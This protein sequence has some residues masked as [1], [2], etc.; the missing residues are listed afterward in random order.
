MNIHP[1]NSIKNI[2]SGHTTRFADILIK[3]N[4]IEEVV[5]ADDNGLFEY[6]IPSSINDNTKIELTS[7]VGGGFI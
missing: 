2:I 4:N 7:N 1:I 6:N 3:Y 5:N